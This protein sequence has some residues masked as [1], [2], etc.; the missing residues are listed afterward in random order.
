MAAGLVL[1]CFWMYLIV[2]G[3]IQKL[4]T[5]GEVTEFDTLKKRSAVDAETEL[6]KFQ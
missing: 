3:F 2:Q 1:N 4:T 6:K 5:G